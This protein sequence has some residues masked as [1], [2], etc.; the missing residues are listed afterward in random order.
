M[1]LFLVVFERVVCSV[2]YFFL[3]LG[4]VVGFFWGVER[5]VLSQCFASFVLEEGVLFIIS[6]R[7]SSS[8]AFIAFSRSTKGDWP[9]VV[10]IVHRSGWA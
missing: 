5:G 7:K 1:W 3:G 9:V 8:Y 10:E 6:Y 4:G 2:L